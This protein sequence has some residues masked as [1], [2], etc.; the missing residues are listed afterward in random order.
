ME[1]RSISKSREVLLVLDMDLLA[2]VQAQAMVVRR[3]LDLD[4]V[5]LEEAP[6]AM[7]VLHPV[8]VGEALQVR[9]TTRGRSMVEDNRSRQWTFSWKLHPRYSQT[10]RGVAM[11]PSRCMSKEYV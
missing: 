6:L 10:F 8:E 3:H 7:V 9:A 11:A 2:V 1:L 4:M 5:H